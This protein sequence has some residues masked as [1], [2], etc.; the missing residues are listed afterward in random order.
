MKPYICQIPLGYRLIVE[1]PDDWAD[2]DAHVCIT[3]PTPKNP[4][5]LRIPAALA[6]GLGLAIM[7]AATRP[8][9]EGPDPDPIV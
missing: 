2:P 9:A 1:A 7:Q 3:I 6:S 4:L 5:V 8:E